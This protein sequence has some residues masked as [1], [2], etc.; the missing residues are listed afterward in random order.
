MQALSNHG[1]GKYGP[2]NSNI[3]NIILCSPMK[4]LVQSTNVAQAAQ[5]AGSVMVLELNQMVVGDVEQ[6]DNGN[7]LYRICLLSTLT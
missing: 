1:W 7:L 6:E 2:T 3:A 5:A 4:Y